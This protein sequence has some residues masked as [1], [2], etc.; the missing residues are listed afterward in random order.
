MLEGSKKSEVY[1]SVIKHRHAQHCKK[2]K[3]GI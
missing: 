1:F 3:G 2:T